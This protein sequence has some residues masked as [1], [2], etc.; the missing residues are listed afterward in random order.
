[1]N[2]EISEI[3]RKNKFMNHYLYNK[4]EVNIATV[5]LYFHE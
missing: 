4:M 5:Y 1:M 2:I 3:H